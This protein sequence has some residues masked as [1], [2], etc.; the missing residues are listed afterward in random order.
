MKATIVVPGD[1][2]VGINEGH[3]T[4]DFNGCDVDEEFRL[5][6][7]QSLQ[8]WATELFD[9]GKCGL[10]F[11]D[12]CWDCGR[13]MVEGKCQSLGCKADEEPWHRNFRR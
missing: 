5:Q 3:I 12:E 7:R 13:V 11:E 6:I 10:F 9:M 4:V 1:R 8:D 2:S